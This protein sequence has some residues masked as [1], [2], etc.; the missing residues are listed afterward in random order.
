MF[1]TDSNIGTKKEALQEL[2]GIETDKQK[3][4]HIKV[5]TKQKEVME[6]TYQNLHADLLLVFC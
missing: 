2:S 5:Q 4:E 1:H 6:C 3:L